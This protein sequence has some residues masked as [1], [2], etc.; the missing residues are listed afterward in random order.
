MSLRASVSYLFVRAAAGMLGMLALSLFVRGLGPERYGHF[1]LGI[2]AAALAS[3]L[4]IIPLNSTLARLYGEAELRRPLLAT[5]AGIVW[6]AGAFCLLLALVVELLG[7]SW[8]PKWVL[9]AAA[10]FAASQGAVDYA[11]QTATSALQPA[12]YGKLLL[13]RAVGIC[14]L[15]ITALHAGGGVL[16]VLMGM[17]LASMLGVLLSNSVSSLD[18]AEFDP[19]LLPRISAFALPLVGSCALTYLLQW[20]D[21]YVLA[22]NVEMADVGRYSALADLTTQALMLLSSGLS[23]AWYPRVV[24]AWGAGDRDEAERL[25]SRYALMG[26]AFLLPAGLGLACTLQGIA[27][28]LFG[29]EYVGL[30]A[31]LPVMLVLAAC[32]SVSKNFFFD[33][34][35]LLAERVWRQAVGIALSAGVALLVMFGTVGR[36][37]V[38]AAALGLLSGQLTGILYSIVAGRGVLRLRIDLRAACIVVAGC[39]AMVAVLLYWPAGGGVVSL[40]LRIMAGALTYGLVLLA[41][42]LDGIRGRLLAVWRGAR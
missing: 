21:R 9:P 11:A 36:L 27:A 32:L 10:V 2:A 17:A 40:A 8:L 16:G 6:L 4:L 18:A 24:Q 7:L 3:N 22:H 26:L 1:A 14:G 28:V 13:W 31:A 35:I 25:M 12:R 39:A 5:T 41:C 19:K 23:S 38:L 15:G 42:D 34:R 33:V 20:G 30:P 29:G 37:G